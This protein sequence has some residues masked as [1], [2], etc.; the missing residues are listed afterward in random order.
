NTIEA[1]PAPLAVEP[2]AQ[3]PSFACPN[4]GTD[5]LDDR[6]FYN[7][8][9]ETCSLR[10]D[11]YIYFGRDRDRVYMDHDERGHET[12]EHDCGLN[13]FCSN[14]EEKLPWP[15]Y[16]L[17]ELDGALVADMPKVIADLLAGV[18]DEGDE[19]PPALSQ[20]A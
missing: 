13:A 18:G 7:Y 6:G 8:C 1:P 9:S 20:G 12:T 16:E 17:R 15:L 5:I 19:V 10:E 3:M 11:N 2:K 14:G 4:C